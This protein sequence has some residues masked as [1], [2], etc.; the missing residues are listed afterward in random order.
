MSSIQT[1]I[2]SRVSTNKFHTNR[3]VSRRNGPNVVLSSD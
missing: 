3:P 1:L 2:E